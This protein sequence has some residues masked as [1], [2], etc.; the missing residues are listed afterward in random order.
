MPNQ[1]EHNVEVIALFIFR[2][3]QVAALNAL[4]LLGQIRVAIVLSA[5][6]GSV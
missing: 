1:V 5:V 2:K 3:A 6:R 4:L